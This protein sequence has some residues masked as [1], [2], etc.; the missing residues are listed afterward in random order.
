MSIYSLSKL[1]EFARKLD[2]EN[3]YTPCHSENV[4]NLALEL[5][6]AL[7]I[8]GKKKDMI[9][10]ACLIHDVGK[11]TVGAEILEK[12]ER[13][14]AAEALKIRQHPVISAQ[15]ANQAGLSKTVIETIYY[16]HVWYNGRGYPDNGHRSGHKI[17]IG[18]RILAV[19]DAFE[20]ITSN[21]SYR[22]RAS[23]EE[24]L[25]RIK[26]SAIRQF[27]PRIVDVFVNLMGGGY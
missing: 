19:C 12:H 10:A 14:S 20:A 11:A 16:H 3:N 25:E 21:R 27:D 17:P 6:R 13:L 8:R 18:A 4:A 9:I 22:D 2:R 7:N 5:C 1:K 15:L 26:K 23:K 24:A